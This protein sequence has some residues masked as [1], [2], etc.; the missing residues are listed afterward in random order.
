MVR[1]DTRRI[2][3][4]DQCGKSSIINSINYNEFYET[5]PKVVE[6]LSI[7]PEYTMSQITL[8]LNDTSSTHMF[9]FD[10]S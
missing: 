7:P 5:L 1:V 6:E 9:Y 3:R 10:L 4:I 2:I 8:L